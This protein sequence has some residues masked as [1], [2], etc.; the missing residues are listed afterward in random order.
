MCIFFKFAD[1]CLI[2]FFLFPFFLFLQGVH[3]VYKK[4]IIIYMVHKKRK[5]KK[6]VKEYSVEIYNKTFTQNNIK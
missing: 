3:F 5:K 1:A 6:K 4:Y 2:S